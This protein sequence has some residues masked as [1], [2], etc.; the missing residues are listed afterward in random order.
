MSKFNFTPS[1]IDE[2]NAAKY[3]KSDKLENKSHMKPKKSGL[4]LFSAMN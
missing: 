4:S 3:T 1:Y 2:V